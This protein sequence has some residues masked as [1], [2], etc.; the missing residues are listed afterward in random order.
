MPTNVQRSA[1]LAIAGGHRVRKVTVDALA[2]KG[3]AVH[4]SPPK[5]TEAGERYVRTGVAIRA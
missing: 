1:M 3:F 5:L 4:G 2:R